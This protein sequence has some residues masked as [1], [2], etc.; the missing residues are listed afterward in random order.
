MVTAP[1]K[2]LNL[3]LLIAGEQD[4]PS[5]IIEGPPGPPNSHTKNCFTFWSIYE[6][7]VVVIIVFR[8]TYV[9]AFADNLVRPVPLD[10]TRGPDKID[11]LFHI[12]DFNYKDSYRIAS[13][14]DM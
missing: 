1:P 11:F 12:L 9:S 6:Q 14:F 5:L 8:C 7:I 10:L 4:R 2:R 13:I 3:C